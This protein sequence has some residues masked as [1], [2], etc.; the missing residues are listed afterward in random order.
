MKKINMGSATHKIKQNEAQTVYAPIAKLS[1]VRKSVIQGEVANTAG[2]FFHST[3]T[4]H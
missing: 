3:L 2:H 4:V 1:G